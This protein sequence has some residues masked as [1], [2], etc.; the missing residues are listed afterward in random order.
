MLD[1]EVE[2]VDAELVDGRIAAGCVGV[3]ERTRLVQRRPGVLARA[4]HAPELV[5][6]ACPVR[7]TVELVC[8]GGATEGHDDLLVACL[9][10]R[11]QVL[12][13]VRAD[14][15]HVLRGVFDALE[16]RALIGLPATLVAVVDSRMAIGLLGKE[17][18]EGENDYVDS[19]VGTVG[20]QSLLIR[21]LA[22]WFQFVL[23]ISSL[24]PFRV[25][26]LQSRDVRRCCVCIELT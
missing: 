16:S 4:E 19:R 20:G 26:S 13:Q 9:A 12:L 8:A 17:M 3:V 24:F 22:L 25:L 15:K 1:V 18:N 11:V 5:G 14:E 2:A 6:K 7:C 23:V 21:S 10:A